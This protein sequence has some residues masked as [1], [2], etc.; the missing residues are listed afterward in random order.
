MHTHL[1]IYMYIYM[2]VYAHAHKRTHTHTHTQAYIYIYTYICRALCVCTYIRPHIYAARHAI[3]RECLHS[4][5]A[6]I[7]ICTMK[8][9]MNSRMIW[10]QHQK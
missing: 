7:W 10:T 3:H 9:R 2:Y 1:Y 8:T 6:Y 4:T 5:R